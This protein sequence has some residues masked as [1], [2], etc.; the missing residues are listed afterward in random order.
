MGSRLIV[1]VNIARGRS[2][3]LRRISKKNDLIHYDAKTTYPEPLAYYLEMSNFL[4]AI[5]RR[6]KT[7]QTTPRNQ[8]AA[9]CLILESTYQ[10]KLIRKRLT[11][12]TG[13]RDLTVQQR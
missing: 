4:H 5:T 11:V 7:Q 6:S 2:G 10:L 3:S 9:A 13:F 8:T 1:A 12:H